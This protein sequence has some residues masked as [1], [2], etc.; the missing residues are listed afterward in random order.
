MLWAQPEFG[1]ITICIRQSRMRSYICLIGPKEIILCFF[2][3]KHFKCLQ[4]KRKHITPNVTINYRLISHQ[5]SAINGHA[6]GCCQTIECLVQSCMLT[7]QCKPA[8]IC[9]SIFRTLKCDC[10]TFCKKMII[11]SC[12]VGADIDNVIYPKCSKISYLESCNNSNNGH[13]SACM[14]VPTKIRVQNYSE[15]LN[16]G[17]S[18]Q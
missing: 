14:S 18:I 13:T 11:R 2:G 10:L 17:T 4:N 3:Y 1:T 9:S 6:Y 5:I 12:H 16:I 8:A 7:L 15:N